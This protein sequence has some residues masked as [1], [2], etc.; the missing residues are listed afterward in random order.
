MR[1]RHTRL[2]GILARLLRVGFECGKPGVQA[3]HLRPQRRDAG[4]LF[5]L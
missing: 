2:V 5:R 3:R 4:I 1:G